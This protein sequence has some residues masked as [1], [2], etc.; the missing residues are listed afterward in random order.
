MRII[1]STAAIVFAASI[2]LLCLVL[3]LGALG[4]A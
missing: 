1:L 4:A 2:L 3:A